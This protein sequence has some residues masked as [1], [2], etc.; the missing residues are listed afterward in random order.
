MAPSEVVVPSGKKDPLMEKIGTLESGEK[1]GPET[2]PVADKFNT[3]KWLHFAAFCFMGIQT[4]AYGAVGAELQ[5]VPTVGFPVYC[6]KEIIP[7]E[8]GGSWNTTP[9][10]KKLP[11]INPIWL[12]TFFV[13]LAAFDHLVTWLY[14]VYKPESARF[15]IYTAQ[16]NPLRWLEYSISASSM[17]WG[18]TTLCG[19]HDVHLIMLIVLMTSI[20]MLLGF[21]IE[22]LPKEDDAEIE[23]KMYISFSTLRNGIYGISAALI[24][25]PWLVILCYFFQ[26]AARPESTMP[27]FVYAAF[28]GTLVLFIAFGTNSFLHNILRK[29][30]FET[31]EIIYVSLSFTA[32]TFLAADVFGGLRAAGN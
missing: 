15:W 7:N 17:V 3:I 21:V 29:Y 28:L 26:S 19:I 14:M 8:C 22:I 9:Y 18:I 16:S 4:L 10:A 31:T 5:V 25:I 32:K 12:M 11:A 23:K 6:N 2:E 27:D 30:D 20:G 13:C 24:F 1:E